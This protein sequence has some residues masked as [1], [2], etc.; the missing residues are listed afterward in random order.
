VPY[1]IC[2]IS[3]E[4]A[5]LA[6]T[7]GLADVSTALSRYLHDR[8]EDVRVF[9]PLYRALAARDDLSLAPVPGLQGLTLALGEHR[10]RYGVLLGHAPG[11]PVPLYFLDCPALYDRPGIYTEDAD[12]HRRFLFL[13]RAALECCQHLGFAPDILHCNDWHTAFGPLYLKTLYAWDGLFAGTKSVLTMH[14]VGYQG[15]FGSLQAGDLGLGEAIA[16]LHQEDLAA[17]RVNSLLHGILHADLV[18]TVSPTYAREICTPAYGY[19]LERYLLARGDTLV[20]ILNGVDYEEWSPERDPY[21]PVHFTRQNLAGKAVMKAR[22]CERAQIEV[23]PSTLLF[24]LVSRLVAQKGIEL[25]AL[26]LPEVLRTRD[27]AVAAVGSGDARY[28]AFLAE[29]ALAF[30]GRVHFH[31]GY[32]E[33]LGHW[34]EAGAD[35]FLMPSRYEPCGLNQM[36]SLRYGTVPIVRRTGGLA[37]S[38]SLYG[39]FNREGTGIVFDD[40]DGPA[41]AWALNTALD[42]YAQPERWRELMANGMAKDFSWDRQG[43]LYVDEYRRLVGPR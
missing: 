12:E 30:P 27:C 34:I 13:T 18:T 33:E 29:L 10:Y 39:D 4:Y 41:I 20:G 37:D 21:L 38:V 32:S 11:S 1:R 31:R 35:A 7:G 6:K 9:L 16:W 8:G 25:L 14:N 3:A 23:G 24:G 22:L 19:G 40:F 28:E 26:A 43:A 5:P 15:I 2:F 42:L 36:Y 17:G